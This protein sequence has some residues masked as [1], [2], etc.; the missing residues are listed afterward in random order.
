[1]ENVRIRSVL[2]K[3]GEHH[4]LFRHAKNNSKLSN[5]Q[6]TTL[7]SLSQICPG[8]GS[9][10]PRHLRIYANRS[11][12]VDFDEAESEAVKPHF[13]ISL[14]EGETGVVE[15]PLRVAAF[16]SVHALSLFFVSQKRPLRSI[17]LSPILHRHYLLLPPFLSQLRI[18]NLSPE[19]CCGRRAVKNILSRFS[20]RHAVYKER[21]QF[22]TGSACS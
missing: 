19:R 7:Y 10:T 22:Q 13:N 12:I 3:L 14:L 1:M 9:T 2:L 15:Y 5:P 8:R 6:L 20:R 21:S 18:T 16:T 11:T 17:T 4:H